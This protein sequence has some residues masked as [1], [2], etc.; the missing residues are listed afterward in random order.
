M[1]WERCPCDRKIMW[2]VG[3]HQVSDDDFFMWYTQNATD[4]EKKLLSKIDDFA[5]NFRDMLFRHG[6]ATRLLTKSNAVGNK[7]TK[8]DVYES[9]PNALEYFS[10][11]IKVS[12]SPLED[13]AGYYD[14]KRKILCISSE[15]LAE[16]KIILHEMIHLHED[17]LDSP[18][19]PK[20]FHDCLFWALY[21]DLKN[22]ISCLDEII[23]EN[24]HILNEQSLYEVGGNHDLTFLLKSFD[25]DI[26]NKYPLGTV[27]GYGMSEH[28]IKTSLDNARCHEMGA[29]F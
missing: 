4:E 5:I 22:K 17:L 16:D 25:L 12:V 6:T 7:G 13:C 24:A 11:E 9:V 3:E 14:S 23:T 1:V 21:S 15:N 27:F 2:K 29:G 20:Y 26:R 8:H 19:V 28:I 10:Y 18:D